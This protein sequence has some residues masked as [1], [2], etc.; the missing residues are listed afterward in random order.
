MDPKIISI[1]GA[2]REAALKAAAA[3]AQEAAKARGAKAE[4]EAQALLDGARKTLFGSSRCRS[5]PWC[6]IRVAPA[7]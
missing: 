2:E 1:I 7:R 5:R 4:G 3:Q 6:R